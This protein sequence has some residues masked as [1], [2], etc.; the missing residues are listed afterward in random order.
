MRKDVRAGFDSAQYIAEYILR[1]RALPCPALPLFQRRKTTKILNPFVAGE[2]IASNTF[3][4]LKTCLSMGNSYIHDSSVKFYLCAWQ[5][6]RLK[7]RAEKNRKDPSPPPKKKPTHLQELPVQE[8]KW[9]FAL[10]LLRIILLKIHKHQPP[11]ARTSSLRVNPKNILRVS[12]IRITSENTKQINQI[13][14]RIE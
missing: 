13:Q 12:T 14:E 3:E 1:R 8:Q 2:T 4:E 9:N 10:Q 7:K 6:M 11:A 5:E